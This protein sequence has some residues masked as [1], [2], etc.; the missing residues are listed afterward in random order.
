MD[1]NVRREKVFNQVMGS[2]HNSFCREKVPGFFWDE[3]GR[4]D[5]N[6]THHTQYDSLAAAIPEY[7]Q[8]SATCAAVTAYNLACAPE[9]LPRP[10]DDEWPA[11]GGGGQRRPRDGN[12]G[13]PPQPD[14][15]GSGSG[16]E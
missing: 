8:Q 14:N 9:F 15:R 11:R 3:V 7:L 16:T 10:T 1:V 12:P 13:R 6:H 5:Y 4:A 2:D